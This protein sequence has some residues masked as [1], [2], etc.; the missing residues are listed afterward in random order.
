MS[1]KLAVVRV[2]MVGLVAVGVG[3]ASSAPVQQAEVNWGWNCMTMGNKVCDPSYRT[4]DEGMDGVLSEIPDLTEVG[5][6]NRFR[7]W[8]DCKVLSDDWY[9]TVVCPDGLVIKWEDTLT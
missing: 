9:T 1:V 8:E 5:L 7:H 2:V 6:P 3:A 4:V